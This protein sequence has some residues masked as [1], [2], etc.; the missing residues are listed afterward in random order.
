[1]M[2]AR[3][4]I[5]AV[6]YSQKIH[7]HN[8]AL[9]GGLKTIMFLLFVFQGWE[10]RSRVSDAMDNVTHRWL[11]GFIEDV[12]LDKAIRLLN[13]TGLPRGYQKEVTGD[14]AFDRKRFAVDDY[15]FDMFL[16]TKHGNHSHPQSGGYSNNITETTQGNLSGGGLPER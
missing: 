12:G 9:K 7:W 3:A 1:M 6:R 8:F 2:H 11:R 5:G 4:F 10:F 15:H 14:W 13:S 16:K